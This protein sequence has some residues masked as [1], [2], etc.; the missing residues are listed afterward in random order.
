VIA[1]NGSAGW[2]V[3]LC[4][5][6]GA[7]V[8]RRGA[9]LRDAH[10]GAFVDLHAGHSLRGLHGYTRLWFDVTDLGEVPYPRPFA[11]R[12]VQSGPAPECKS[13]RDHDPGTLEVPEHAPLYSSL[14]SQ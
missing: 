11:G 9:K 5:D 8:G 1:G 2:S 13:G 6:C 3:L 12:S 4:V 14:V 7:R 10:V